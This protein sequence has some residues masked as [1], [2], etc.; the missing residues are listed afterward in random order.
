[1]SFLKNEIGVFKFTGSSLL[2]VYDFKSL[3]LNHH[4]G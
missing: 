1:M 4:P 2:A 3:A